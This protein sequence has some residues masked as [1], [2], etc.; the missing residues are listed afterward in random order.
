MNKFG[1]LNEKKENSK[2]KVKFIDF[3]LAVH[4]LK[5]YL[6][7]NQLWKTLNKS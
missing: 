1:K 3:R 4:K 7:N 5:L 2:F 6:K